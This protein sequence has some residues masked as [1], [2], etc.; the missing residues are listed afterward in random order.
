MYISDIAIKN[1]LVHKDT[2]ISLLPLT[3]FV[4]SVQVPNLS[5]CCSSDM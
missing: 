2:S 1:Y 5:K 3:V 4:V